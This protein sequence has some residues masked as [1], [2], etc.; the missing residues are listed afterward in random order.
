MPLEALAC[1][2]CGSAAVREVKPSTY[3]CNHCDSVFKHVDP[4]KLIVGPAF[5]EHGNPVDVQ[6]QICR[7]GMCSRRCD[8]VPAWAA[9]KD[10]GIVRT[11]GFGYVSADGPYFSVSKLL[12]S[13]ALARE[14]SLSHVCYACVTDAVPVAAEYVS[15]G[16]ICQTARC[17]ATSTTRCPCCRGAFCGQCRQRP[18]SRRPGGM[19][20]IIVG[21]TAPYILAGSINWRGQPVCDLCNPCLRENEPKAAAMAVTIC[22]QDYTHE[23]IPVAGNE[24]TVAAA[25]VRR[26]KRAEEMA[27]QQEAGQRYAVEISARVNQLMILD[28]NCDRRKPYE[29]RLAPA[30][31]G[32]AIVDERDR[33]TPAAISKVI[34]KA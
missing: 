8:V 7:T 16:A 19:V 26:K 18:P 1:T 6:C 31:V 11:E 32:G 21:D 13:L 30:G 2:N 22:R 29:E 17:L 34:W 28:G 25:Q 10:L 9:R 5:C 3:F 24:F 14:R 33:I 23:L 4:A 15:S 20:N 12:A 27:R